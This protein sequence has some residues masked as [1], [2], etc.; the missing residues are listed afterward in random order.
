[1]LTLLRDPDQAARFRRAL[2]A[3]T[4]SARV[5]E[6]RAANGHPAQGVHL[7]P[8]D[9]D[10]LGVYLAILALGLTMGCPL[11]LPPSGRN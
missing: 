7:C 1:M 5:D 11:S 6:G 4:T 8:D 10:A 9:R 3:I 2:D